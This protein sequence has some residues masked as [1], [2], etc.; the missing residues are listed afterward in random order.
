[1]LTAQGNR[2]NEDSF[3]GLLVVAI[4]AESDQNEQASEDIMP[5]YTG[6]DEDE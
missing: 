6:E 3:G 2:P 5:N 1:M 4:A